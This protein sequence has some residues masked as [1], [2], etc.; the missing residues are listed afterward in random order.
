MSQYLTPPE[1]ILTLWHCACLKS[2]LS[3]KAASGQ[4]SASSSSCCCCIC[5]CMS[6]VGTISSQNVMSLTLTLCCLTMWCV[7]A[8]SEYRMQASTSVSSSLWL[9]NQYTVLRKLFI[10]NTSVSSY[11]NVTFIVVVVVVVVVCHVCRSSIRA[12]TS[13]PALCCL[14]N[15]CVVVVV[16][17]VVVVA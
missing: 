4:C 5:C 16:V 1:S 2:S 7:V 12:M 11:A 3:R 17:V 15:W 13:T 14:T 9:L 6:F 8:V 10:T